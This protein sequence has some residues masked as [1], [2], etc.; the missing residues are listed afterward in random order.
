MKA[1]SRGKFI[2]MK[3]NSR[4]TFMRSG[5]ISAHGLKNEVRE[6]LKTCLRSY[7]SQN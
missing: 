2:F 1:N 5:L 4:H 7:D 3:S 6:C